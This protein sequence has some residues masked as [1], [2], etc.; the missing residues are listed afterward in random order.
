MQQA[1]SLGT[2]FTK[3]RAAE[4]NKQVQFSN[5]SIQRQVDMPKSGSSSSSLNEEEELEMKT[6]DI[7]RRVSEAQESSARKTDN[8][9]PENVSPEEEIVEAKM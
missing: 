8:P 6:N 5:G 9:D 2:L 4:G 7:Y 3:G 1:K